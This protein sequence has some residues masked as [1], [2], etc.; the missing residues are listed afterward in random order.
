VT[1]RRL[2]RAG[3]DHHLE[4]MADEPRLLLGDYVCL[5]SGGSSGERGVFVQTVEEYADFVASLMRRR[6]AATGAPD[7][8]RGGLTIAL[9]AAASPVHS[10]G[11]GAATSSAPVRLVAVPA[12]V[13]LPEMVERLNA[14]QPPVLMGYPTKLAQ[15]AEEQLA[16]RLGIAPGS[17]TAISELLTDEDRTVITEAFGVPVVNQ[18]ASTEGLTGQSDP[19]GT[20]ITFASDM[21]IAEL[22]DDA[23]QPVEPGVVADKVLV[24]N[25][26]NFTQPLVRY[27]LTD[28]FIAHAPA[29]GHLRASVEG[30]ADSVFH[31]GRVS[32]HPL[33]VRT[34]MVKASSVG[35][36]Q[37]R[38]TR[39]GIHI[40]A[41]TTAPFDSS[42]LI[43]NLEQNL[44]VAG[45]DDPDVSF[46]VVDTIYRDS[47]TGKLRRFVPLDH[48]STGSVT[49]FRQ[50]SA[51]PPGGF[52]PPTS[53][54]EVPR[55]HPLSYG[56]GRPAQHTDPGKAPFL[57]SRSWS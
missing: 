36:Y 6:I 9:V 49:S 48:A 28:H 23:N 4:T 20:I 22:V 3:V 54:L 52:E 33:A 30:R 18:F 43:A 2:A 11:F 27:E 37:V 47:R 57:G 56:G 29:N 51:A 50:V 45:L 21:C 25:L 19:G 53:G 35:E 10:T 55:S 5:A 34:V 16:G 12:T 40:D 26:H 39:R 46:R 15:L 24:T 38:Q 42:G 14:L 17:V 31:Y 32:L 1:D 44:L 41:V 13:P 8:M 7:P